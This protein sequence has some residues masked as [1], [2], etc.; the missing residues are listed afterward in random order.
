MSKLKIVSIAPNI[1]RILDEMG[2]EPYAT[3][4]HTKVGKVEVGGW[5]NPDIESIESMNPDMVFTSDGLQGDVHSKLQ[6][7]G[8]EVIHYEPARFEELFSM[9]DD[10]GR[11]IGYENEANSLISKLRSR[12][13]KV[14]KFVSGRRRPVVY[15]EEWDKPPMVAGNWIPNM[16]EIAGGEY[17]FVEPGNRSREISECEYENEDPDIFV[18]HI[19]GG[20]Q[21]DD[22]RDIR[23]TWDYPEKVYFVDD[24]Y[25][26]QL[27]PNTVL[28]VENIA[29]IIHQYPV[30]KKRY[31]SF[32]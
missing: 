29:S 1:T 28:G 23:Q 27:S 13:K 5:L 4:T 9:I 22:F 14:E 8:L 10:I 11:K 19:C 6:N 24:D 25:M 15:C 18:S 30:D 16:I 3:T 12:I 17:P 2:T 20:G 21:M 7:R 31:T 32:S 26:N